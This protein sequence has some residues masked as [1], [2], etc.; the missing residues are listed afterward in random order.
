MTTSRPT[1]GDFFTQNI[2]STPNELTN[3][4]N[5]SLAS[6]DSILEYYA[7]N[8]DACTDLTSLSDNTVEYD[9][10]SV[11]SL[12]DY[13]SIDSDSE[14][15][16]TIK[17]DEA[18]INSE[19]FS[20]KFSDTSSTAP[21]SNNSSKSNDELLT[22]DVLPKSFLQLKGIT[23]GNFNMGCNFRLDNAIII[24][25]HYKLDILAVQ[26]HTP[27][28]RELLEG[29]ITSI[30]RHCNRWGYFVKISKLQILIIDKQLIAC[31]RITN[32][33]EDGGIL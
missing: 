1:A 23:V 17:D 26:E 18:T 14:D 16:D 6:Y 11:P 22:R 12:S 13:T 3:S 7:V 10:S 24:M 19:N 28:N 20:G 31:H 15:E 2:C 5:D 9:S 4:S 25:I 33:Y 29:E 8:D 27:W 21:Q 30:E 32:V